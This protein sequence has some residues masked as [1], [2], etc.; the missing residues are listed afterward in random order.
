MSEEEIQQ[1]GETGPT[2]DSIKIAEFESQAAL[3][4]WLRTNAPAFVPPPIP[5]V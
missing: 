4:E 2:I 1:V 5:E 3:K